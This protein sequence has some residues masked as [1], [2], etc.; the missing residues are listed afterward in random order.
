[1]KIV[2]TACLLTALLTFTARADII[3]FTDGLKTICQERAWEEDGQIKCEYNGWIIN[4]QKSD[5][6]RILHTTPPKR[7]E[8]PDEKTPTVKKNTASTRDITRKAPTGKGITK[9]IPPPDVE[10]LKFYDPRR[11]NK[12]WTDKNSKHKTYGEAIQALAAKYDRPVDWIKDNIGETNDLDQIHQNLSGAHVEPAVIEVK[13][14]P[15]PQPAV[16]FYNPRRPYPYWTDA[17]TKHKS[18]KEAIQTLATVYNRSP[19]WIK[20]N[21]G[22]SNVLSEI[23]RNLR[24]GRPQKTDE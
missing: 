2:A 23:H 18:Y 11:P 15:T 14:S 19:Q 6:S 16:E 22:N 5:V 20:E 24:A 7:T 1:M 3:Y 13:P 8:K 9:K 4:Y 10:G 12:Y 17:S 21:M